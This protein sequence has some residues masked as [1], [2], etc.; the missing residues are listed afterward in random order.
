MVEMLDGLEM[1]STRDIADEFDFGVERK[2]NSPLYQKLLEIQ[3]NATHSSRLV[4]LFGGTPTDESERDT[5]DQAKCDWEDNWSK[6]SDYKLE[7]DDKTKH[8]WHLLTEEEQVYLNEE[9][10]RVCVIHYESLDDDREDPLAIEFRY[11]F[12]PARE[13]LKTEIA[14]R[15]KVESFE[16]IEHGLVEIDFDCRR[17]EEESD[18]EAFVIGE[19]DTPGEAIDEIMR[20]F[21]DRDTD[22]AEYEER[23]GQ[24]D[25]EMSN[26]LF[27]L[28]DYFD[29]SARLKEHFG[30]RAIPLWLGQYFDWS[31]EDEPSGVAKTLKEAGFDQEPVEP[32]REDFDTE[33]EF[34]VA[35]EEFEQRWG[36]WDETEHSPEY[37]YC[38]CLRF[39]VVS[40][41]RQEQ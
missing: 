33:A 23:H 3:S 10:K 22:K 19:G 17:R 35:F 15:P 20:E 36:V 21:K 4:I 8:W 5:F 16:V 24:L 25:K 29:L 30:E 14:K 34:K 1:W 39:R 31:L 37:K 32:N 13:Q 6:R 28:I 18:H 38:I 41:G 40:R 11:G 9:Y 27:P 26:S 2:K 7:N 12:N